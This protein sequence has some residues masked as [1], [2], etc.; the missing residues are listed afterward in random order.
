MVSRNF[1]CPLRHLPHGERDELMKVYLLFLT[2]NFIALNKS[3]NVKDDV[4]SNMLT[5]PLV[6]IPLTKRP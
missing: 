4:D 3:C 1:I 6:L 5:S 2:S